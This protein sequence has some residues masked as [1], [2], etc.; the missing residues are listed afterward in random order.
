MGFVGIVG[1]L[2]PPLVLSD[3][4]A[5]G[6]WFFRAIVWALVGLS[7]GVLVRLLGCVFFWVFGWVIYV[8]FIVYLDAFFTLF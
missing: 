3:P 2:R 4:F 8:Y 7:C 5:V 1:E 6:A